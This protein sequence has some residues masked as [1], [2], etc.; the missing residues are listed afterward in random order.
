[1][2]E[3]SKKK[4]LLL[5]AAAGFILAALSGAAEHVEWI[6][7]LCGSFSDGCKKAAG[8][9]FI[10]LPVWVWGLAFYAALALSIHW[11]PRLFGWLLAV[12][13]GC[14]ATWVAIAIG[15]KI[16]CVFCLG[17]LVVIILLLPFAFQKSFFWRSLALS[18]LSFVLSMGAMIYQEQG[19]FR[20][21]DAQDRSQIIAHFAG[22]SI[23]RDEVE[24]PLATRIYELEMQIYRL[25]Q[26]QAENVIHQKLLQKEAEASGIPLTQVINQVANPAQ[27]EVS[28]A[29]VNQYLQ[30][31]QDRLK[32]WAGPE[33]DLRKQVRALVQRQKIQQLVGD[34][35]KS[36]Y[37]KYDVALHIREPE[38]PLIQINVEGDPFL[39]PS[40]AGLTI[41]QFSDYQCPSCRKAHEVVRQVREAY[42]DRV[43][44]V[45]K[46]YPLKRHRGSDKAAEAAR[47][48]GD[49]GRF[50]EY[51]DLLFASED[52][53]TP[54]LLE[55]YAEKLGLKRDAF[56]E[57][58]QEE[59]YKNAV[60]K[61]LAEGKRVG[62]DK[63]PSFVIGGKMVSGIPAK[64]D[65]RKYLDRELRKA[66]GALQEDAPR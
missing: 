7:A 34:Y 20:G 58:L 66:Q 37:G 44:Y 12:G 9:S 16:I 57:C 24:G 28:D 21:P 51:Q 26:Q 53:M 23:T 22:E 36:L 32:N 47:C 31:N 8:F 27:V 39:G 64:D 19:L 13:I 52:S 55:Q 50:W 45:F 59:K 62:I 29:E 38:Y 63:I 6:S 35:A 42:K 48:A 54:E 17:N 33:E 3:R 30:K 5:L 18:A 11:F 46:D 25:K 41:V 4:V 61:D 10:Y 65:F 49:Q 15:K 56:Q 40:N 43:K 1:M 2:N 14:E 60:Q